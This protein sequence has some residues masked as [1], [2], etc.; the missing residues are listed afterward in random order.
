MMYVDRTSR[1]LLHLNRA[2]VV[3]E[4]PKYQRLILGQW[5]TLLES[6]PRL[7]RAIGLD[8]DDLWIKRDDLGGLGGG[9][10]KIR[11]LEWTLG[12]AIAEGADSI[13]TSGAAQSNHARL[14]AAAGAR[15]GLQTTLILSGTRDDPALGNV[16]LDGLFGAAIIW[17]GQLEKQELA[18]FANQQRDKGMH[19]AVLPLGGS[20]V[21]GAMGYVEC[22]KELQRQ[23]TDLKM[24]VTAV[25]SGG[26]MAGLVFGL[27]ASKVLGVNCSALPGIERNVSDLVDGLAGTSTARETLNFRHDQIGMGYSTMTESALEAMLLAA[28]YEGLVLDPIYTGRAF[29]GLIAAV[30]EGRISPGTRTIFLHT[31]GLPALLGHVDAMRRVL[32]APN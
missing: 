14:T 12:Q 20:T 17:V 21:A 23:A 31:G 19:P 27:G 26:T 6:A 24:V 3:N 11:K 5:P 22:A 15:L 18:A 2:K 32:D 28:R 10:N 16:V 25:G 7:S 9:G 1:S 29:A 13:I 30:R 8:D 4:I